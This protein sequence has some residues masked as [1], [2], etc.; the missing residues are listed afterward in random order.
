MKEKAL[1]ILEYFKLESSSLS[2][3]AKPSWGKTHL[4]KELIRCNE[5][6]VYI[7]PLRALAE[8]FYEEIKKDEISVCMNKKDVHD[9]MIFTP[10]S[11]LYKFHKDYIFRNHLLVIDEVH[12]FFLWGISFREKLLDFLELSLPMFNKA[13]TLSATLDKDSLDFIYKNLSLEFKNNYI[14]NLGNFNLASMPDH[15]F[16]LKFFASSFNTRLF[17][18]LILA[19]KKTSLVFIPFRKDLNPW[20]KWGRSKKLKTLY[21]LG[22]DVTR[23]RESLKKCPSPDLIIA[24]TVLSHGV[25][26][27][28]INS[29][30]FTYKEKSKALYVQMI[31]RAGRRGASYK[32]YSFSSHFRF[33]SRASMLN[34]IIYFIKMVMS[35]IFRN[36]FK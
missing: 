17:K 30:F 26:L 32:V 4:I 33:K 20:L 19:E 25:N 15:F 34:S 7:S 1:A 24:T 27:P 29:V 35:G 16:N 13:L 22:G 12:L 28:E 5:K 10:E 9:I 3:I 36:Y 2:F 14:L 8:E 23:F 6:I 18:Y 31:S 11:F 21:C